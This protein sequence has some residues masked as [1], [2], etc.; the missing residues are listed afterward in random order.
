MMDPMTDFL[1]TLMVDAWLL[2]MLLIVCFIGA[3]GGYASANPTVNVV[4]HQIH[5]A[6][7]M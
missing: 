4:V 3:V 6:M 5:A 1:T 7:L 2:F